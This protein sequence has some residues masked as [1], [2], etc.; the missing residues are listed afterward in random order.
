[1]II[2][3]IADSP[4]SEP[5]YYFTTEEK[6]KTFIADEITKENSYN[7]ENGTEFTNAQD[8]YVKEIEVQ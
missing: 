4:Y 7:L 2:Y 3:A 6:A 1:M 5:D 8:Y